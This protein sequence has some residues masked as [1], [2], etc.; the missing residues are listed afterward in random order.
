MEG[1][2][3]TRLMELQS[4]RACM[5]TVALA[6]LRQQLLLTEC[7]AQHTA[8]PDEP[9]PDTGCRN[10]PMQT[11]AHATR[12]TNAAS[13]SCRQPHWH[14]PCHARSPAAARSAPASQHC[15]PLHPLVLY[16]LCPYCLLCRRRVVL[17]PP[18]LAACR[19]LY[20]TLPYTRTF[21]LASCRIA[22]HAWTPNAPGPLL[23][24]EHHHQ[25]IPLPALL[26]LPALPAQPALPAPAP[27]YLGWRKDGSGSSLTRPPSRSPGPRATLSASSLARAVAPSCTWGCSG[28]EAEQ[29]GRR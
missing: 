29:R 27:L 9:Q 15:S 16:L 5:S 14:V 10:C 17:V 4:A 26:A 12:S 25:S 19:T 22:G 2:S 24:A 3:G 23:A 20:H 7:T 13:P 21:R 28:E 18:L 1:Q 11:E 6:A 8:T